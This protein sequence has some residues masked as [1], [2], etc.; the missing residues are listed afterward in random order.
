MAQQHSEQALVFHRATF[1]R[2][3]EGITLGCLAEAYACQGRLPEAIAG[4]C[5]YSVSPRGLIG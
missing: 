4:C 1:N 2:R 3:Y 5:V